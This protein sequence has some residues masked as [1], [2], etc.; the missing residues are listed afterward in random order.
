MPGPVTTYSFKG[1]HEQYE[2]AW[3]QAGIPLTDAKIIILAASITTVPVQGDKLNIEGK[4]WQVSRVEV[5]P[6]TATFSC[7]CS[8]VSAPT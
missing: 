2:A 6:A 7:Q 1:W 5:D 4:W 3:A 8:E